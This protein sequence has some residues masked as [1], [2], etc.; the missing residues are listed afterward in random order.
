MASSTRHP[1]R[2]SNSAFHN[3]AVLRDQFIA[4]LSPAAPSRDD[5]NVADPSPDLFSRNRAQIVACKSNIAQMEKNSDFPA[6]LISEL[7]TGIIGAEEDNQDALRMFG[8]DAATRLSEM[9]NVIK[10]LQRSMFRVQE[11]KKQ[12]GNTA[13]IQRIEQELRDM[14][15]RVMSTLETGRK[16]L[17]MID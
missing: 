1:L 11:M 2:Q 9:D 12:V 10:E 4:Y 14:A 13:E 6:K 3:Y 15:E 16:N 5:L 7:W 17:A 8:E